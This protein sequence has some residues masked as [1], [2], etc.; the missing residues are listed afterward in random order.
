MTAAAAPEEGKVTAEHLQILQH[1]LGVDQYGQGTPYRNHFCAGGNDVALCLDLV[2]AGL[3][4][5]LNPSAMLTGGSRPF[6][7]TDAGKEYVQTQSPKPP[8]LTRSQQ[9]YR[10][11]L[12]ADTG[13]SSAKGW[14]TSERPQLPARHPADNKPVRE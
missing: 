10:K 5:E 8:K 11:W 3:M 4:R 14:H 2:Q 13:L 9:R 6:A 7:V 12:D 1:S